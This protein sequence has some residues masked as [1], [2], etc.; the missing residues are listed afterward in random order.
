MLNKVWFWLLFVGVAYGF[1]KGGYREV[2]AWLTPHPDL[3]VAEASDTAT[4]ETLDPKADPKVESA[5]VAAEDSE[6]EVEEKN[7]LAAAGKRITEA[8]L[9]AATLAVEL[10]IGLIGIM[11][12]WLG[13]LQIATEAGLV[14]LVAR[15]MQPI[16]RWLFPEVP[17]GHPAQGAIVMNLAAN[18]L[19]LE[20]AATPMGLK[21][22]QE[23][24]K[25]NPT[26]DTATNS[27]AMFLAINTSNVTLI[28]IAV[29]GYRQ[30]YGSTDPAGTLFGTIIVTGFATIVAI[31]ATRYLSR[32]PRYQMQ[33]DTTAAVETA[34]L[35]DEQ[36]EVSE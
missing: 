5:A 15:W 18:M 30:A 29:I 14:E 12:L 21:A 23:L 17:D 25:L 34:A 1:L 35:A 8:G 7:G 28:P 24:Q 19:G 16:M 27:M 3:V 11:A 20:N 32:L 22:M 36:Q 10:C 33:L 13:L 4:S 2:N 9:D 31:I 6:A 26:T